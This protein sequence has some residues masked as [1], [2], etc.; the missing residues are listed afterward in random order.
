MLKSQLSLFYINLKQSAKLASDNS[1]PLCR[2]DEIDLI[3]NRVIIYCHG[4]RSIIKSTIAGAIADSL[5]LAQLVPLQAYCLGFYYG[6]LSTEACRSENSNIKTT[7]PK[8]WDFLLSS[9]KSKYKILSYDREHNLTYRN[10]HTLEKY[11]ENIIDIAKN[12]SLIAEF[13]STQACYIGFLAGSLVAKLG[14][15]ILN[16]TRLKPQLKIVN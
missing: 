5:T 4:S 15:K 3:E 10:S 1:K 11:V 9:A 16:P 2:I 13:D 8:Q 7:K 12:E 14:E 6:K